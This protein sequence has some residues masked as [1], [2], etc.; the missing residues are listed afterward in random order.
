MLFER[1]PF[2]CS[3]RELITVYNRTT[4]ISSQSSVSDDLLC[5]L[6]LHF[7]SNN[8]CNRTYSRVTSIIRCNHASKVESCGWLLRWT[9]LFFFCVFWMF[10]VCVS[11]VGAFRLHLTFAISPWMVGPKWLKCVR[12]KHFSAYLLHQL[13][14]MQLHLFWTVES[15][16]YMKIVQPYA[17]SIYKWKRAETL[18]LNRC[19]TSTRRNQITFIE[20]E[21]FNL[22]SK[23]Y[24]AYVC[25]FV[26]FFINIVVLYLFCRRIHCISTIHL[27][28]LWYPCST[29]LRFAH[30]FFHTLFSITLSHRVFFFG[31][32]TNAKIVI[33]WLSLLS[34]RI[35]EGRIFLAFLL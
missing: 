10:V 6:S 7:F 11:H 21:W 12:S 5:V 25:A 33:W 9:N 13:Q 3:M 22:R 29:F 14:C 19:Y 1:K 17:H 24:D 34:T 8:L 31:F 18:V 28:S 35:I 32:F 4:C 15:A 30:Q 27:T 26:I 23:S 2:I 20:S 16:K